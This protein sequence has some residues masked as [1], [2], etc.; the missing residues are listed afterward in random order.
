MDWENSVDDNRMVDVEAK[1]AH[2]DVLISQ[3]SDV[4]Y[5]QQQQLDQLS[6][7]FTRLLE[8]FESLEA[9]SEGNDPGAEVP[10]HY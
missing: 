6:V 5:Q 2:Q 10:P 9:G 4:I 1:L 7:R 8:Q 3:M